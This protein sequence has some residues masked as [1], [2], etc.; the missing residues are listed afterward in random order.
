MDERE[1]IPFTSSNILQRL[2]P[3]AFVLLALGTVF[4][5]YQVVAGGLTLLIAGI[6]I[7]DS[8]VN[9][10]RWS[11]LIGQFG[12]ILLP[13]LVLTWLRHGR[14][15]EPLRLRLPALPELIVAMVA[16]FALQQVL[17]G[18]MLLQDSIPLPT[19]VREFFDLL[20]RMFEQAYLVLLTAHSPMEFLLVIVTVALVPSVA[21]ELLFRGL[22]QR[23]LDSVAGGLRSAIVT[24]ILFG[25]YHLNPFSLVALGTL[26]IFLGFLVYRSQNTTVAIAA[27]FFNNFIGCA[28]VYLNFDEEFLV[29]APAGG[30]TAENVAMNSAM[31]GVVFV[32]AMYYFLKLTQRSTTA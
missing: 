12:F 32:A 22:V 14:I 17:Q 23:N 6:E 21:E 1:Q 20:K 26:G 10:V 28:A 13:T 5:L 31:F 27:H 25:L 8:N 11:T 30:A 15:R 4:L 3:V 29:I 19:K 7:T 24:G 18:Y 9:V 16:I 2:H